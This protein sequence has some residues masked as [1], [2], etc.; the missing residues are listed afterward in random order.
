MAAVV[1]L[2][3]EAQAEADSL[4]ERER[5]ALSNAVEKLRELG[6]ALGYPHSSQVQGTTLRELRPRRGNSPWRAFYQRR[7]DRFFIVAAIGPEAMRDPR[8]FRRAVADALDRL[9][10]L[11]VP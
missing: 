5:K 7:G 11:E 4:P 1:E 8:R 3:P 6:D 10:D 9:A 2:L